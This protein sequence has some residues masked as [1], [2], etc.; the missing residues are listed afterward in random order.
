MPRSRIVVQPGRTARFEVEPQLDG[1]PAARGRTRVRVVGPLPQGLDLHVAP[2]AESG[3]WIV[4]VRAPARAPSGTHHLT[5]LGWSGPLRA[6]ASLR[7][8]VARFSTNRFSI[9][10]GPVSSLVPGARV[11][12]AMVLNNPHS[13]ALRID[14]VGVRIVRVDAPRA[15]AVRPC[16]IRDYTTHPLVAPNGSKVPGQSRRSLRELGYGRAQWPSVELVDR[17][18]NQDGCKGSTVT[19]EYDGTGVAR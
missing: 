12:V 11:P 2:A 13:A 18:V 6:R 14:A 8:V 5:L 17:P 19:I 7:F 1:T 9:T 3:H 16:S 10:G 4:Q 15:T